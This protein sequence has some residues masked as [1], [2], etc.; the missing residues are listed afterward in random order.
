MAMSRKHFTKT[1]AIIRAERVAAEYDLRNATNHII[2]A[3][4][5]EALLRTKNIAL[6]L[7][8]MFAQDNPAFDRQRFYEA[9]G[10]SD[11]YSLTGV[12]A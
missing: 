12:A 9:A 7:A 8:D 10:I 11:A 2:V 6:S 3:A 1:A 4:A 5:N